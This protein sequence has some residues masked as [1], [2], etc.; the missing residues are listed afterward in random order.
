MKKIYLFMSGIF[1][2]TMMSVCQAQELDRSNEEKILR[3]YDAL[4]EKVKNSASSREQAKNIFLKPSNDNLRINTACVI[5][6]QMYIRGMLPQTSEKHL[7]QFGLMRADEA[8]DRM[9]RF[10]R[11]SSKLIDAVGGSAKF[12]AK[13]KPINNEAKK[14]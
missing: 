3:I 11:H 6:Y 5:S 13:L 12:D 10:L 9:N 4:L 14:L 2:A 8:Q 1:F 7:E